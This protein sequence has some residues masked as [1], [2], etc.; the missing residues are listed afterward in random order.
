MIEDGE[1]AF[2]SKFLCEKVRGNDV[3]IFNSLNPSLAIGTGLVEWKHSKICGKKYKSSI[4]WEEL[5]KLGLL[6]D[7]PEEDSVLLVSTR[8]KFLKN[9]PQVPSTLYLVLT[10]ECNL[11]CK[12]CPFSRIDSSVRTPQKMTPEIAEKGID[13]WVR[14][15]E[16]LGNVERPRFVIFY[17]GEPLLNQEVLESSLGYIKN[18][19]L[20]KRIP[21]DVRLLLDTNGTLISGR[22]VNLLKD[23]SV[24]VTVALDEF[25]EEND[26]YRQDTGGD[27]TFRKVTEALDYLKV[28]GI[29]T[30]LSTSLTPYT[31]LGKLAKATEKYSILGIG[32]NMLR[33]ETSHE[34]FR[35]EGINFETYQKNCVKALVDFW[36]QKDRRM[37]EFQ[38]QRRFL[39]FESKNFYPCNCGGFGEHVVIQPDGKIGNCPWTDDYNIG[40]LEVDL[41]YDSIRKMNF[42]YTRKDNLPLFNDG[43]LKC[44]SIG[45]CGGRCIWA[46]DELGNK[47]KSGCFLSKE[48]LDLLV[49]SNYRR[50]E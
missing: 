47:D 44:E 28:A 20:E 18:L 36:Q 43:C 38:T 2:F 46:D 48:M 1:K 24:E 35:S 19:K 9:I 26:I 27:G 29:K 4:L 45:I 7:S 13:F 15:F 32:A 3:V 11:R 41:S 21:S 10:R 23:H 16:E 33:G 14:G 17:G 37:V 8:D 34:L 42:L 25:S 31:K 40:D 22:T 39:S 6:V 12:Y 50:V 49:W 30:Y 5:K